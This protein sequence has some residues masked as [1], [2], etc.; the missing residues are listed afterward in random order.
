[1]ALTNIKKNSK[2]NRTSLNS[3]INI[4]PFVDVMLV[5]LIIF[6]VTSPMLVTGIKLDLPEVSS[7]SPITLKEEPLTIDIDKIGKIYIQETHITLP[8]LEEKLKAIT[9][10][11]FDS[12]I[13]VRGDKNTNYGHI[14]DVIVAVK[15]AGFDK[16]S[17]INSNKTK[18][19][20]L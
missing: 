4:T 16:V 7:S 9:N 5:L 20:K 6:M 12:K 18:I 19:Q 8:F 14:M 1:M 17:L 15:A 10:Q 3:E 2:R 13:V 11:Q